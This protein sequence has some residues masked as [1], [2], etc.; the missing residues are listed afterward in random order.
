[1]N[2]HVQQ[3]SFLRFTNTNTFNAISTWTGNTSMPVTYVQSV[4]IELSP[5]CTYHV[6]R[7]GWTWTVES[8]SEGVLCQDAGL[9]SGC[10]RIVRVGLSEWGCTGT[11]R[12]QYPSIVFR[13]HVV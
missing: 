9:T 5:V 10:M 4:E 7:C 11:S 6:R 12:A 8:G 2:A 1:M 13:K 3:S